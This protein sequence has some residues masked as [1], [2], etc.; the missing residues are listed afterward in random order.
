MKIKPNILPY[1][2]I[3]V[4]LNVFFSYS[5]C[6]GSDASVTVCN[7]ET[8][9]NY[10]RFNLFNQLN[11]S[12]TTGGTWTS[13][14]PV[15]RFALNSSTGI[16]N[17]WS[18][19]RFGE[20]KFIYTNDDCSE[21]ATVTVFLGGYPGEDNIDG[22]ANACEDDTAVD[23]FSF[24]D[25]DLL[26]LSSDI[27]GTWNVGT[28]TPPI[29]LNGNF[30]NATVA[31]RGTHTLTYTVDAVD[32]CP[33]RTATIVLEVHRASDSGIASDLN[34]CDTDDLS[35]YSNLN[36]FDY[37]AGNDSDGIW[38]DNDTTGQI[39]SLTDHIINVEQI[40]NDFGPGFYSFTY[41]VFPIHGV[42]SKVSST[43]N[44]F[45]PEVSGKFSVEKL[46]DIENT[47]IKIIHEGS[48]EAQMVYNI[49][50]EI[51][52]K[53]TG[54]VVYSGTQN[55][56]TF[57]V[58]DDDLGTRTLFEYE[59]ELNSS[60]LSSG[61][62]T[63]RTVAIKDIRNI[64]CDTYTVEEFDFTIYNAKVNVED[65]CFD[66]NII[67][68]EISELTN[69]DG[70]ITNSEHT[71]SYIVSN[72]VNSDLIVVNDLNVLFT[73]GKATLSL[74]FS[75]FPQQI[76]EYT[77][78]I[79]SPTAIGL[80]CVE[81]TF[82]IKRVPEDIT[83]DLQVDNAC[84]ATDMKIL[85]DAPNLSSGEYTI[86]YEVTELNSSTKLIENTIVFSGGNANFNVDISGLA[87]GNYNV[88]L[89]SVQNDTDPCRT[90]F[91][92]EL[93][94][95]FSINGIPD[96]PVLEENQTLCLSD[97]FPNQPTLNNITVDEGE[98]LTW[99]ENSSTTTPLDVN[100]ALEE[101]KT[102]FVTASDLNNSCESSDR[103]VV[104]IKI[105]TT[106]MV[107]S[108][109]TNPT[110]CGLD[111][112]T[113]TD[114]N[115]SVSTGTII[116]Y[117]ANT[118]G[119][120]LDSS[121][122]IENNKSYFAVS[123]IDDCEHHERL[124]FI[125]SVITPPTPEFTGDTQRC[126]LNNPTLTDIASEI[127]IVSGYD[128]LWYDANEGGNELSENDP[129]EQDTTYFAVYVDPTTGCE[130]ERTAITI[131]LSDCNPEDYDFFIPDGFS[132][133][134]DGTND[135]FYIPFI[136]FFY[137]NYELEIFNRYG[138]SLFKGNIDNPKWNGQNASG[139]EVTSGVYFYILNYNKDNLKPK[140][141]R[142]Y[143]SK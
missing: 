64:I 110:F 49:D 74:D 24:L 65:I 51:I 126:G 57:S 11:G 89:K 101:G 38:S 129:I 2:L 87:Q 29:A 105:I 117:D 91:E 36:L 138:Q 58:F 30:F 88:L 25:N 40:Y 68:I 120:I 42:C 125:A 17:L 48:E 34:I 109:D 62:Y 127:T 15:N 76:A 71:L 84:N 116:W 136:E 93:T 53:N 7:K 132:P 4:F 3:V 142:I 130:G 102:Y 140:Q 134:N 97:F 69:N 92:F 113:L 55:D 112:P 75:P 61:S 128:L 94:E 90:Q 135:D 111:N 106:E 103:S 108:T 14:N 1:L 96:A 98:N 66:T 143:L 26:S 99:Y 37:L 121:T 10:Q 19:N 47:T 123:K 35:I 85:I 122:I 70:T 78:D 18:I 13:E 60:V 41:T 107:S 115:A 8:D 54:V 21:S 73:D 59:F 104:T 52:D 81:E 56:V 118:A 43:V 131:D 22:G 119:S 79:T 28:G 133:N 45:I 124:E 114:F 95:S 46:C 77:I 82:T 50:Y 33:S 5:Q 141:G 139:S 67:D 44:I 137:P 20:H 31:G 27:N 12:P 32:S 100:T 9:T 83:L 39:T 6:A 23:L 86:T 72:N 16:L 80:N 63:I